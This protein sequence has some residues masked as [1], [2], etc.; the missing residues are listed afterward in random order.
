[1]KFPFLA[2]ESTR[3]RQ[4]RFVASYNRESVESRQRRNSIVSEWLTT[5]IVRVCPVIAVV[6]EVLRESLDENSKFQVPPKLA[7]FSY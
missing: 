1:M 7:E 6:V 5:N 3:I 4:P 2:D